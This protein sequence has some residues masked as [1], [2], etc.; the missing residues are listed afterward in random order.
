MQAVEEFYT[1]TLHVR[2]DTEM[3]LEFDGETI[4]LSVPRKGVKLKSGWRITPLYDPIVSHKNVFAR[5]SND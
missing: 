3:S 4:S 5:Y 1:R 2:E